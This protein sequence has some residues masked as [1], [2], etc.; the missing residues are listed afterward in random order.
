MWSKGLVTVKATKRQTLKILLLGLILP[1]QLLS[2]LID[3]QSGA[4]VDEVRGV[5]TSKAASPGSLM[6]LIAPAMPFL[7]ELAVVIPLIFLLILASYYALVHLAV[8]HQRGFSTLQ[9]GRAWLLGLRSAI[10]GGV[11]LL[12]SLF[13]LVAMGQIL[14]APAII[15]AVLTLVVPIILV[16][17]RRGA[18]AS[19]WRAL[20]LKYVSRA[21]YSGWTVLFNLLTIG[22]L[23]YTFLIATGYLTESL[24]FLDERV[25]MSRDLWAY[26]FSGLPFGPAY[27]FVSLFETTLTMSA[28]SLFPALTAA[29]Y[30]TV[31]GKKSLGEA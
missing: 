23:L 13:F 29:L 31:A 16:A 10:P 30:F 20:S 14:I 19:L 5:F 8:E 3:Y 7:T 22:A 1:Q 17:E 12:V 18:F 25:A 15:M 6:G 28:L 2:F 21:E 27:V 4:V 9:A 24:L 11:V 26:T